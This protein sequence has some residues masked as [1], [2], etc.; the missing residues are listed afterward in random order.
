MD[1]APTEYLWQYNPVTGRVAGANQNYGERINILHSNRYL[2]NRMQDIQRETN[3]QVTQRGLRSLTGGSFLHFLPADYKVSDLEEIDGGSDEVSGNRLKR[4]ANIAL[5]AEEARVKE[6]PRLTTEK[7]VKQFPPV[8]YENPFSG[9]NFAYEFDPLYN[10]NG[11]Q[12]TNPVF[13]NSTFSGTGTISLTGEHPK[14]HGGAIVLAGQN[15]L[16]GRTSV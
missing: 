4:L 15:P 11:N 6:D 16:L 5:E 3:R 12:F 7:F 10:P 8:V 2:Y 9:N 14:L 1:A 13:T